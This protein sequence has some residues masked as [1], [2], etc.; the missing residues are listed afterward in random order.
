[1]R[2]SLQSTARPLHAFPSPDQLSAPSPVKATKKTM[3][4]DN[5]NHHRRPTPLRESD[6][7][8]RIARV[9]VRRRECQEGG[10]RSP[11]SVPR[12]FGDGIGTLLAWPGQREGCW[13]PN[14]LVNGLPRMCSSPKENRELGRGKLERSQAQS[15]TRALRAHPYP[16]GT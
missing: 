5:P 6:I 9:E 2:V 10:K 11:F 7:N 8:E 3:A 1:M 15:P 12:I 16:G 13:G 4:S 14:F